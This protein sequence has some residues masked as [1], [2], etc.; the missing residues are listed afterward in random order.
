MCDRDLLSLYFPKEDLY[1][2]DAENAVSFLPHQQIDSC[3]YG[4]DCVILCSAHIFLL[5]RHRAKLS[6]SNPEL[7]G[8]GSLF[9]K[10]LLTSTLDHFILLDLSETTAVR[11]LSWGLPWPLLWLSALHYIQGFV[12]RNSNSSHQRLF[13]SY[14]LLVDFGYCS[15]EERKILFYSIILKPK[16]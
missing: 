15:R 6:P 9:K 16:A 12:I 14:I 1:H 4:F 3:K 13:D 11:A 7:P 8:T 10:G 2:R 5:S